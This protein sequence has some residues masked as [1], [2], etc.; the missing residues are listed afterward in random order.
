MRVY[1]TGATGFVGAHVARELAERGADVRVEWVDLL[2]P[3]GLAA[4]IDGCEAVFH[5]AALYSYDADPARMERVNVEG[6]A[7]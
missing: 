7:T 3:D 4:V 1:V 6:R 5:V 2:D